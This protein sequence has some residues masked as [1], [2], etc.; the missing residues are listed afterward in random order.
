MRANLRYEK[1][2]AVKAAIAIAL[3]IAVVVV[4]LLL[5]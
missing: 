1:G 4:R 2:L 3:V 5:L